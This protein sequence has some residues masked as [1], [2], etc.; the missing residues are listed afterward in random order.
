MKAR[1]TSCVYG[2][3]IVNTEVI[4]VL[5]S[6]YLLSRKSDVYVQ[7][8]SIF[9]QNYA[10]GSK[11]CIRFLFSCL[12]LS[13]EIFSRCLLC[14]SPRFF[15]SHQFPHPFSVIIHNTFVYNTLNS[16]LVHMNSEFR[17]DADRPCGVQRHTSRPKTTSAP[18]LWKDARND[19]KL[20]YEV[21][22]H[23]GS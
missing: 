13:S 23:A 6:Y 17:V 18:S 21:C 2:I 1:S 22:H 5:A 20:I 8:L 12:P 14:N 16:C 4:N 19:Q 9:Q 7:F 10:E 3:P 15:S 11:V